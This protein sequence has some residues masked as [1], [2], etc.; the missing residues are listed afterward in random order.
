MAYTFFYVRNIHGASPDFKLTR[1]HC[2]HSH[3]CKSRPIEEC[4]GLCK[5]AG[6]I[7][8]GGHSSVGACMPRQSNSRS[9]ARFEA[10]ALTAYA[11]GLQTARKSRIGRDTKTIV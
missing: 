5:L 7:R 6:T 11:D 1:R 4:R 8:L 2:F 9:A 3:S 10:A